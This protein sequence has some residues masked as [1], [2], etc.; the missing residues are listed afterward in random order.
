MGASEARSQRV[1]VFSTI[2]LAVAAVTTAWCSFQAAR[3]TAEYR[4]ASGKTNAIRLDAARAQGL[5]EAEKEVD[6]LTFSQWVDAYSLRRAELA[7]FYFKRF[8]KEFKPAVVAWMA[9]RPLKNPNAPPSPFAMPQYK[10]AAAQKVRQFDAQAELSS[11]KGQRDNQRSTNYV[12]AVVL[13]ASS[14]FFAGMSK[15]GGSLRQQEVLL[16]IGWALLLGT[17]IWIA[18]SPVS[19]SV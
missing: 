13:C 16:G 19:F 7:D 18:T 15:A 17:V 9:T 14:L 10:L 8:R 12:L 11:A 5:V 3:W 1:Q 4:A 6:V 2:L